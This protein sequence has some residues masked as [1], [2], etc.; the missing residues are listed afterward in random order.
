M[1]TIEPESRVGRGIWKPTFASWTRR[2]FRTTRRSR[3]TLLLATRED[4]QTFV[5][6][7]IILP[8]FLV[9]LLIVV[10]YAVALSNYDQVTDVARTGARAASIARFAG[11]NNPCAAASTAINNAKGNMTLVGVPTC[12]CNGPGNACIPASSITV[13]ITVL[14]QNA[15]NSFGGLDGITDAVLPGKTCG[16]QKC[17]TSSATAVLQ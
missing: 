9:V 3:R 16:S 2:L 1:A 10:A 15:V 12:T 8:I 14:A 7:V 5:E 6:F 11:N 13:S 4:G 17:W